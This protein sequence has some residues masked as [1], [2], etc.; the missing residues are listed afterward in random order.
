LIFRE[1]KYLLPEN[2]KLENQKFYY[3]GIEPEGSTLRVHNYVGGSLPLKSEIFLIFG[4]SKMKIFEK[5]ST[6]SQFGPK[7]WH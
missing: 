2:K 7:L 5:K 3:I 6:P 1:Q 4:G